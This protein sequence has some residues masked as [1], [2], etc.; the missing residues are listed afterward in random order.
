MQVV[1]YRTDHGTCCAL[2][3]SGRKWLQVIQMDSSGIRVRKVPCS[4]ERYMTPMDYPLAKAKKRFRLAGRRFG[5]TKG[6][7]QLLRG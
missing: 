1:R 4:D 6:A 3:E 7:K 5:I 2:V